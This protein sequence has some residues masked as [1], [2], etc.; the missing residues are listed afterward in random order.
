LK[1]DE[2]QPMVFAGSRYQNTGTTVVVQP[3]GTSTAALKTPL[4]RPPLVQGFHRRT[5]GQRLDMIANYFLNDAGGF[6][7]LCDANNT[8]VPDALANSPLVGIPLP[9]M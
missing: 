3:D 6:W 1:V 4:P 9:G 5:T 8:V 7:R 2:V